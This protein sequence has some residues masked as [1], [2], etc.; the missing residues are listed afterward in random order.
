VLTVTAYFIGKIKSTWHLHAASQRYNKYHHQM[1]HVWDSDS[2][3]FFMQHHHHHHHQQH[4]H[5]SM[6]LSLSLS[7]SLGLR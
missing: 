2:A 7:L 6:S 1:G 5:P 4:H 3:L